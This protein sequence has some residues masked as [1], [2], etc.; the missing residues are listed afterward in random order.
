MSERERIREA[1]LIMAKAEYRPAAPGDGMGSVNLTPE[2]LA[3]DAI[4]QAEA[5]QYA[6]EF[7]KE[8]DNGG[9][10]TIGVSKYESNRALVFTIEAARLMCG[11]ANEEAM[12]LLRYAKEELLRQMLKNGYS[13]IPEYRRGRY[14]RQ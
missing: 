12:E 1:Y 9:M 3:D 13:F 8:E 4:L 6:N 7:I 14:A 11:G 10:F 2:Q 5:D